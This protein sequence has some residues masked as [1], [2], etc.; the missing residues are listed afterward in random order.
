LLVQSRERCPRP[1]T[2]GRLGQ[3]S[4]LTGETNDSLNLMRQAQGLGIAD[5]SD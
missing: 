3:D 5:S 2:Y 4:G 1:L